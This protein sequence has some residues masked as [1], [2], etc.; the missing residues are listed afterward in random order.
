VVALPLTGRVLN[1]ERVDIDDFDKALESVFTGRATILNRMRLACT[2]Y[3][4]DLSKKSK[5]GDGWE[6][7]IFQKSIQNLIFLRLA[8][9]E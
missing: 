8:G 3:D 4:K 1:K 6:L 7:S 5:D 9:Y 2:F